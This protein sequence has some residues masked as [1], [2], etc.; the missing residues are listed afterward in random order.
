MVV[1]LDHGFQHAVTDVGHE[2]ARESEWSLCWIMGF[3]KLFSQ[4]N[5]F[6]ELYRQ[7]WSEW[8]LCWIMGFNIFINCDVTINRPSEWSLRWN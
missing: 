2:D 6:E 4:L 8:S 1:A 3:N 5:G 7:A